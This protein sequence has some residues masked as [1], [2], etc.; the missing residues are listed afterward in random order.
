[1]RGHAPGPADALG[2]RFD[3]APPEVHEIPARDA[4]HGR[5]RAVRTNVFHAFAA[6]RTV[7]TPLGYL[8]DPSL[9]PVVALARLHGVRVRRLVRPDRVEVDS[10][11]VVAVHREAEPF[12]GHRTVRLDVET[13]RRPLDV[14]QGW[15]HVPLAQPLGDLAAYLLDPESDDGAVAWNLLDADLERLRPGAPDA[16]VRIHRVRG[17]VTVP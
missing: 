9:E 2:L 17:V 5:S 8:L 6:T 3:F 11:R 13:V 7:P 4:P 16:F 15:F 1:V 14:A 10:C 12:Q